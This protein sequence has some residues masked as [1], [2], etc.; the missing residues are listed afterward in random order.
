[1]IL[2][3]TFVLTMLVSVGAVIYATRQPVSRKVIETRLT[4]IKSR[5][6]QDEA[7]AIELSSPADEAGLS[8]RLTQ[9]LKDYNFGNSLEKLILHAGSDLTVGRVIVFGAAAAVVFSLALHLIFTPWLVAV[10]GAAF[11]ALTPYI[12]LRFKRARRLSKFDGALADA[13]D[14]MSRALRAGHSTAS[15][16]EVIAEESP[17]PL[18]GEFARCFQQQKFGI[19]F[20]EAMLAMGER[21]PSDDL[22]FLITAVLV[23]KETGGDLTD[24]LDRTTA[25]IRDRARVMGEVRTRTAQ[26]R[27]TGWILSALPLVMMFLINLVSPGYSDPMFPSATS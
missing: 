3:L 15:S 24:I 26:G 9:F 23:Q 14:L 4:M 12:F 2:V 10:P 1:M 21:V 18:A 27:M 17:E 25:V 16:I 11:G 6:G 13:I 8:V 19:P 20:R 5:P 22:Q 7:G